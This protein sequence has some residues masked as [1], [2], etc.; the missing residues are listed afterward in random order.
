MDGDLLLVLLLQMRKARPGTH[1]ADLY[2]MWK[3]AVCKQ[4]GWTAENFE[5]RMGKAEAVT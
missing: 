3:E 5:E 1:H 2:I 4:M